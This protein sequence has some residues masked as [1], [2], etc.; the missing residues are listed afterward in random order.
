MPE[1]YRPLVFSTRVPFSIAT[2]TVDGRVVAGWTY[3]EGRI[4][5]EPFEPL[6]LADAAGVEEE[7]ERLEAFHR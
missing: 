6:L 2:V 5:V 1:P 4:A 7:S 3:R